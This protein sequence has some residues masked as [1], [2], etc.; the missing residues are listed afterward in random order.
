MK[1]ILYLLMCFGSAFAIYSGGS[2]GSIKEALIGLAILVV[3]LGIFVG[4]LVL[5]HKKTNLSWAKTIIFS[6]LIDVGII[7]LFCVGSI[8]VELIIK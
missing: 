1:F 3:V 2:A 5:L 8:I 4:F 7:A 6:I